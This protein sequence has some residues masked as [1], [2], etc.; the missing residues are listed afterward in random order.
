[1]IMHVFVYRNLFEIFVLSE[2]YNTLW[3]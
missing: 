3:Q 1:M 2:N